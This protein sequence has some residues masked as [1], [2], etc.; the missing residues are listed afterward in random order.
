LAVSYIHATQAVDEVW[1]MPAFR[2]PFGKALAPYE[3]RLAM[4]QLIC[5]EASGWL[6]TSDVERDAGGEGRTVDAL[7]LLYQRFP[8]TKLSL[9]LG[10][11][12]LKDLPQW[13]DVDR[14]RQLAS[15]IILRRS[16]YPSEIAVGPA[17]PEV[18]STHVRQMLASGG[19][20]S[21]LVPRRVLDYA[22]ANHVY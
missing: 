20:L 11:D 3:H 19:D 4:C 17:L 2:H 9:V 12:I 22:R 5:E 10:S 18:S 1:L 16:G 14:I 8:D 13:K 6:K 7:E 15:L 21:Q